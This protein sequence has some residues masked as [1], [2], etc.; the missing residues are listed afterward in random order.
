MSLIHC[1]YASAASHGLDETARRGLLR[2]ARANNG[3]LG[4]TGMLLDVDDSF[5]QVLEGE[6]EV[7]DELFLRIAGDPRHGNLNE[8]IR[9]PIGCRAFPDWAMGY[10]AVSRTE[11]LA[12][13]GL[14]D[15][16][17]DASCLRD[18]DAAQARSLLR[19]FACGRWRQPPATA[20]RQLRSA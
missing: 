7:V 8:L 12:T 19:A 1:I 13:T 4:I 9:E 16:F 5:F 11:I 20:S 14:D 15:F 6:H 17:G 18:I 2:Q 3:R 10:A